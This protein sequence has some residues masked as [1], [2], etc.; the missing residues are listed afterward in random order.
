MR[1]WKLPSNYSGAN[2]EGYYVSLSQHR[3]SDAVTRS[4][5]QA[6]WERLKAIRGV[7]VLQQLCIV[8]ENHWAIGWVEWIAIHESLTAHVEEGHR[9]SAKLEDYPVLD[10]EALSALEFEEG[11]VS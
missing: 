6:A 5:F 7:T 8:R 4:N 9:I 10:E 3:D 2:W 11:G 1:M